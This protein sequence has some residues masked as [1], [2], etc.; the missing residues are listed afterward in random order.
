[1][2]TAIIV[3]VLPAIA[4]VTDAGV[5]QNIVGTRFTPVRAIGFATPM[6]TDVITSTPAG[7]GIRT[8]STATATTDK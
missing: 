7:N 1:M 8:G 2:R 5:S 3:C 4:T 6:A